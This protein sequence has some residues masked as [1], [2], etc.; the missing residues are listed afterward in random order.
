VFIS[1]AR[2]PKLLETLEQQHYCR[3]SSD[4]KI[5]LEDL[6]LELA[7]KETDLREWISRSEQN[8]R[9]F[10]SDPMSAIRAAE[11]GL[12]DKVLHQLESVMRS[13]ARKLRQP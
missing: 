5:A 3:T 10:A 7:V 1:A 13:I 2:N 11:L 4:E 6:L 12:D 8:S 9:L